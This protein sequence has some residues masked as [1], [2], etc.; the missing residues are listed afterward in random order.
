MNQIFTFVNDNKD[1]ILYITEA[2]SNKVII[3]QL[4]DHHCETCF[5]D[6]QDVLKKNV[7]RTSFKM[8]DKTR[9]ELD[10]N[11]F[12]SQGEMTRRKQ[13]KNHLLARSNIDLAALTHNNNGHRDQL[14][15]DINT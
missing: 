7:L 9:A 13:R 10:P 5:D 6:C 1:Q 15:C 2:T 4:K 14:S 3:V 12:K 11:R 8:S